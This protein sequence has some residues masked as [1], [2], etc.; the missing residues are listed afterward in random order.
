MRCEQFEAR[1]YVFEQGSKG[2]KFYIILKGTVQVTQNQ[3]VMLDSTAALEPKRRNSSFFERQHS[4]S[5]LSVSKSAKNSS[6]S[7]VKDL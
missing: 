7:V 4:K 2:D 6:R 3:K 5:I 1:Q